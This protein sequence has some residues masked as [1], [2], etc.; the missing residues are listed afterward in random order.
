MAT[1]IFR[2]RLDLS[3][4]V[5]SSAKENLPSALATAGHAS[6]ST[7]AEAAR[8]AFTHGLHVAAVIAAVVFVGLAALTAKVFGARPDPAP[9][10]VHEDVPAMA[11]LIAA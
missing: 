9:V 11:E 7:P 10:A 5:P 4:G 2:G 3:A 6:G 8:A 1:A